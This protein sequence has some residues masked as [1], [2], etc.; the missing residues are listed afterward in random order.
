MAAETSGALSYE[1]LPDPRKFIRLLQIQPG[2][3]DDEIVCELHAFKVDEAPEYVAISYTWGDSTPTRIVT[4]NGEAINVRM[5]CYD[6]LWQAR[7]HN[8]SSYHWLDAISINQADLVEKS[9]QVGMMGDIFKD[10][11]LVLCCLG[12]MG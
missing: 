8:L 4:I 10:A 7:H 3:E 9:F 11:Q 5:N 2:Q 12:E 1:P 6:A